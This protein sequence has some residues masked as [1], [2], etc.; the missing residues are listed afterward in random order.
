M[1]CLNKL[2]KEKERKKERKKETVKIKQPQQSW[3][4]G[5]L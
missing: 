4:N 2:R 5:D 1:R 3:L